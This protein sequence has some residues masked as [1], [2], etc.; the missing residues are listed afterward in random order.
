MSNIGIY[1][2]INRINNKV[3]IGQSLNLQKRFKEHKTDL[4]KGIHV[5]TH[6]Q[7]A[8]NKYG[9]E[10]FI[11]KVIM[12]CDASEL[13]KYENFFIK[14]FHATDRNKGYNILQYANQNPS[15][16]QEVKNKISKANKGRK[17][18]QEWKEKASYWNSGNK[19]NMY[20]KPGTWL[21][22]KF[23]KEH[24]Q[25]ISNALKKDL[26]SGHILYEEWYNDNKTTRELGEKY[27]CSST[28]ISSRI[29]ECGYKLTGVKKGD[30]HY[31]YSGLATVHKG[32]FDDYTH[33]QK[34]KISYRGEIIKQSIHKDLLDKVAN[35]IN[36]GVSMDEVDIFFKK[37]NLIYQSKDTNASGIYRVTKKKNSACNQGFTWVYTYN[38]DDGRKK[39]LSSV[40]LKKLK[41]KVLDKNLEWIE[42][43]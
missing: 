39:S 38:D 34:Y 35:M 21:G 16:V 25:N 36:D 42:F 10:N 2:I 26:P 14:I 43:S 18:T 28:C 15:T 41:K 7:N 9:V 12:F 29:K 32:G 4:K 19:N 23:S 24:R 3:Y 30:K 17:H 13:N 1:C 37:Q 31:T 22:K 6:L 11:F 33:K 8:Y 20:G 27:G 40:D 5:N